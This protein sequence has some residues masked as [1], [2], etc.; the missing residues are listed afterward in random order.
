MSHPAFSSVLVAS[1]DLGDDLAEAFGV[2]TVAAIAGG[3]LGG[4]LEDV[5]GIPWLSR[6][7]L[8]FSVELDV[9]STALS[10]LRQSFGP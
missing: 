2:L 7:A 3:I 10:S 6:V 8:P 9:L 4:R 1:S 5:A